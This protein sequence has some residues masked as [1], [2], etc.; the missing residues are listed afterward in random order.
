MVSW[1]MAAV[2]LAL[3]SLLVVLGLLS[4]YGTHRI[5]TGNGRVPLTVRP[6][7]YGLACEPVSFRTQDGLTLRGW[8]VPAAAPSARTILLCHGWGTNKGEIL[9]STHALAGLGF[10]L[11]YFDFRSCGESDGRELSVG[12]LEARD[13][14]AAVGFLRSHRPG[15]RYAVYGLSM[16]AMVAF[17]GAIRHGCFAAAVLE[18]PFSS[19]DQAVARYLRFHSG[20]PYYPL[21]PMMLF[22]IRRRLGAD[23]QAESPERLAASFRTP[24][25]GVCGEDDLISPPEIAAGLLARVPAPNEL[26]IVPGADH[27]RCA[28]VSGTEYVD[29]LARFFTAHLG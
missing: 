9:K 16:G 8:F 1:P 3:A 17:C 7:S 25:L 24:L 22:L 19:H 12:Y 29:R 21:V 6:E 15:D 14:D 13:F 5:L 18:S 2:L 27:A 4:L 20:V 23:P 11:L 28:A 26:W 10:N